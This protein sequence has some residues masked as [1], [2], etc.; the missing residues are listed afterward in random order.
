MVDSGVRRASVPRWTQWIRWIVVAAVIGAALGVV[1]ALL[2]PPRHLGVLG[3]GRAAVLTGESLHRFDAVAL[4]VLVTAA[5]GVV[6]ATAVWRAAEGTIGRATGVVASAAVGSVSA[7]GVGL[8]LA[9]LRFPNAAATDAADAAGT[10]VALAPG[11]VT[12]M[13][14]LLAPLAAAVTLVVLVAFAPDDSDDDRDD[15]RDDDAGDEAVA[16]DGPDGPVSPAA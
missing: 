15:D 10:V 5:A 6:G 11:L 1:W 16:T 4:F 2:A 9:A 12:P 14:V 8:G 13:A 7:A 3:D